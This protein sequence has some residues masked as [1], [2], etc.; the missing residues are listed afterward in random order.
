MPTSARLDLMNQPP[1]E[2]PTEELSAVPVRQYLVGRFSLM[3]SGFGS[4]GAAGGGG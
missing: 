4:D 1:A 2:G 3:N